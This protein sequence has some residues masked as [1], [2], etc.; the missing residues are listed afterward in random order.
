MS[1]LLGIFFFIELLKKGSTVCY[2]RPWFHL[3]FS[4]LLGGPALLVISAMVSPWRLGSFS[5]T[6]IRALHAITWLIGA[7]NTL[8]CGMTI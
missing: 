2:E 3:S 8:M 7:G 6:T 1:M 5:L 4:A